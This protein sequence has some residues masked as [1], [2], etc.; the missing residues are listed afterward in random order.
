MRSLWACGLRA[1]GS[2]S[3]PSTVAGVLRNI[4]ANTLQDLLAACPKCRKKFQTTRQFVE[5]A[6]PTNG[7]HK[8]VACECRL[9]YTIFG[10]SLSLKS[11]L[12]SGHL[13]NQT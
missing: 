3:G 7:L 12:V 8:A 1:F 9:R 13:Q 11:W 6:V 2:I 10:N 5:Q 4:N